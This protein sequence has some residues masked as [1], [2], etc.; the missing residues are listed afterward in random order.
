MR[1]FISFSTLLMLI[2]ILGC[3]SN[4]DDQAILDDL[5]S[6]AKDYGSKEINDARI[7]QLSYQKKFNLNRT[8]GVVISKDFVTASLNG[9]NE[10]GLNYPID[11]SNYNKWDFM[12]VYPG[13]DESGTLEPSIFFYKGADNGSGKLEPTGDPVPNITFPGGGGGL[14]NSNSPT[15]PPN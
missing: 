7:R 12:V 15:P 8:N 9:F 11:S 13:V 5:K 1:K 14:G 3:Q 6:G 4:F 2:S 10:N